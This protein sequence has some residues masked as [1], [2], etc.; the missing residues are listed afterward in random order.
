MVGFVERHDRSYMFRGGEWKV[1]SMQISVLFIRQAS[2]TLITVESR[3]N[4][5][6][7]QSARSL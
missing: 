3:D 1:S 4:L 2:F 5:K 6:L 7:F